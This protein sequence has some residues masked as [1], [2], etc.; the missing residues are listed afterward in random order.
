MGSLVRRDPSVLAAM[1]EWALHENLWVRRVAMQSL[2]SSLVKVG[3]DEWPR[4]VRYA[5]PHLGAKDFWTRKVIGWVCREVSKVRPELV[6]DFL[7]A[8]EGKMSGLTLREACK[9][10]SK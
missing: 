6:R 4:F 5:T 10:L 9:F 2:L 3:P 1:D 7:S 8:N